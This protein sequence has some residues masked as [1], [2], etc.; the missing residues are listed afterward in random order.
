MKLIVGLGNPGSAYQRTR[1]NAGFMALD[2][3]AARHAPAGIPRAKF[4]GSI[5]ECAIA[6]ERCILLK[7]LSFM[8]RSG[9]PVAETLNFYKLSP[10]SDLLVLVDEYA[11]PL[12]KIRIRASGSAGGHNG[13]AD[14]ERAL[15]TRDYPR[16]RIGI[17]PPPPSYADPADWVLGLFTPDEE[18]TLSPGLDRAA[19]AVEAFASRGIVAAMNAFNPD[20]TPPP[21]PKPPRPPPLSQPPPPLPPAPPSV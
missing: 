19:D 2:R 21:P 8:N 13:L 7:P 4:N 5:L 6:G 14:V 3:V 9:T 1:H 15:G 10:A 12:G 11:L 16:L 17:D 20:P 18:R